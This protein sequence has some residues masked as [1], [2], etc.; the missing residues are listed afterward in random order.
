MISCVVAS[1]AEAELAGGFQVAQLA[2]YYRRILF[3]LGYPQPPTLIRI[4]NTVAI[5]LATASINAKRSKSMDM[6]FFWIVDRVKQGQFIIKHIRGE[7]NIADH[8]TKPLPRI[9]F[10]QF[11][12]YLVINM[13]NEETQ[14]RVTIKTITIP[15]RL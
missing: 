3:D 6:R 10:L 7:W 12:N 4:D 1:V 5:G 15:K 2:A 14:Q 11:T 8:F 9:K 13:D